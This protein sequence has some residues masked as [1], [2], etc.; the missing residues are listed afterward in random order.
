MVDLQCC[1]SFR[2][3]CFQLVVLY[4]N[5]NTRFGTQTTKAHHTRQGGEG[6]LSLAMVAQATCQTAHT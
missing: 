2:C 3:T 4:R 6:H 5:R 1:V